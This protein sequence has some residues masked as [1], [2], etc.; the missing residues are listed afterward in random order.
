MV[1]AIIIKK[2]KIDYI[3]G[4]S[5]GATPTTEKSEKYENITLSSTWEEPVW[6]EEYLSAEKTNMWAT[7]F[8]DYLCNK[9]NSFYISGE[10][11]TAKQIRK[12]FIKNKYYSQ[13]RQITTQSIILGTGAVELNKNS[14]NKSIGGLKR[15]DASRIILNRDE[16]GNITAYF[17]KR[18]TPFYQRYKKSTTYELLTQPE[19]NFNNRK[20]FNLLNLDVIRF[21]KLK[22]TPM[23]PY[24]ISFLRSSIKGLQKL[25]DITQTQI[26]LIIEREASPPVIVLFDT[27]SEVEK[28][29]TEIEGKVDKIIKKV[30]SR[31]SA[32]TPAIGLDKGIVSD[33]GYLGT[34]Q[35][36]SPQGGRVID[37]LK[38]IE[39][40]IIP[41]SAQFLLPISF[42]ISSAGSGVGLN[43]QDMIIERNFKQ[44]QNIYKE[45][46]FDL[47]SYELND[48]DYTFLDEI[49]IEWEKRDLDIRKRSVRKVGV[50]ENQIEEEVE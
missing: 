27:S 2:G 44:L 10:T 43:S 14:L 39:P 32:K 28:D 37:V 25:N 45:F 48:E 35:G 18:D 29:K 47:I 12:I 24:G 41:I 26:P 50:Q 38:L 23:S 7:L 5:I 8:I 42:I 6:Y 34:I 19:E 20:E 11:D 30:G 46:L 33:I 15:I 1:D 4:G 31:I 13:L 40:I 49:N 36:T 21:L 17:D 3:R 9:L 22:E 16:K